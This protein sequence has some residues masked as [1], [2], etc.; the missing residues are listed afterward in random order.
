MQRIHPFITRYTKTVV[1]RLTESRA[2]VSPY[3]IPAVKKVVINCG[4]GDVLTN[5]KAVEEV[6]ALLATVTG[7]K[8]IETKARKAIAGFK[9]RTGMVIGMKVTLR[10]DRMYDFLYKLTDVA[11]PR[12]RDFRGIPA[13]GITK[14]GT[15]NIGIRDT[16]IFPEVPYGATNHGL[17][18]TVVSNA[19][20]EEEAR[21]FYESV[22]FIFQAEDEVVRKKRVKK[23]N[24]KR[25]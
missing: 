15:L 18:V 14:N 1:P 21:T 22:G 13:S 19:T 4:L 7:Q 10:G 16:S 11:L 3:T 24:Y 12:T 6:A 9:I 23:T 20:S 25:K 8:P 17:Q 5:G 2:Y